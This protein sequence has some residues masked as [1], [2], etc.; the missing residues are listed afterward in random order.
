MRTSLL[1]LLRLT[2]LCLPPILA[3][4]SPDP[5]RWGRFVPPVFPEGL[6]VTTSR[7]GFATLAFTFDEAGRL[8]DQLI[9]A[10]SHPVFAAAVMEAARTG[11]SNPPGHGWPR[12]GSQSGLILRV[13]IP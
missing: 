9:L 5:L 4:D 13:I 11:R 2:L 3:D 8:T 7:G 10:A 6:M 12:G 1:S